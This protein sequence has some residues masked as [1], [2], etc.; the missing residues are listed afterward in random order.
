MN[1]VTPLI[2]PDMVPTQVTFDR[3]ELSSLFDLYGRFVSA[4]LFRDYAINMDRETAVFSAFERATERPDVQIVKQPN[5]AHK[6]GAFALVN[7]HGAVLKRGQELRS[8]LAVL[9][10]KLLKSVNA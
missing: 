8:V 6:Q 2:Q 9:E 10:R 4:G 7:R 5:L 1:N 3:R